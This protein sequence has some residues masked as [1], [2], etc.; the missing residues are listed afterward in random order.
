ML[1]LKHSR[2]GS[3]INPDQWRVTCCRSGQQ[4]YFKPLVFFSLWTFHPSWPWGRRSQLDV[5]SYL[6]DSLQRGYDLIYQEAVSGLDSSSAIKQV[7]VISLHD[8]KWPASS[9]L[10]ASRDLVIC[11]KSSMLVVIV[12]FHNSWLSKPTRNWSSLPWPSGLNMAKPIQLGSATPAG[13]N[14]C[15]FDLSALAL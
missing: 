12:W 2:L 3:S 8:L 6:G 5:S 4:I 9:S 15:L 1:H 13:R 7:C 14:E 10:T 11:N